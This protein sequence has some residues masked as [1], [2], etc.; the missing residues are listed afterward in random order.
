MG[1]S[2]NT[3]VSPAT[4]LLRVQKQPERISLNGT[5]AGT[6]FIYQV[7]SHGQNIDFQYNT[8]SEIVGQWRRIL[9]NLL[10]LKQVRL[11]L[12]VCS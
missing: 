5:Q 6:I 11:L 1:Q 2:S 8:C 10:H 3:A 7:Y 4:T 12:D 9:Y